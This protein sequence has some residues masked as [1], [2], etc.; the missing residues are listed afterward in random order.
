M[1]R[2]GIRRMF[3]D[4]LTFGHILRDA[5]HWEHE[6]PA[7]LNEFSSIGGFDFQGAGHGSRFECNAMSPTK[8]KSL[9]K[10]S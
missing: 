5:H 4:T 10:A 6:S 9:A 8:T 7:S 2:F 1:E 3:I